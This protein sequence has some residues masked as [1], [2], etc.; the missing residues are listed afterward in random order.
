MLPS[1]RL[2]ATSD[3]WENYCPIWVPVLNKLT[4]INNESLPVEIRL[5]GARIILPVIQEES[6]SNLDKAY[7]ER[8]QLL[9][10]Y[11]DESRENP[12]LYWRHQWFTEAIV[13]AL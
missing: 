1:E 10:V 11:N 7:Y 8:W 4:Q 6:F 12:T 5:A 3:F 9:C 2:A 13:G